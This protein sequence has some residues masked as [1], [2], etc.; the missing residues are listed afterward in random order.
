MNI[1]ISFRQ[2]THLTQITNGFTFY[3]ITLISKAYSKNYQLNLKMNV[4]I[5]KIKTE[6]TPVW[7]L[8]N[9]VSPGNSAI[10]QGNFKCTLNLTD[11]EYKNTNFTTII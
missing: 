6:K 3:L 10:V 2:V 1:T 9:D 7:L 11:A 8:E 5:N 4:Y